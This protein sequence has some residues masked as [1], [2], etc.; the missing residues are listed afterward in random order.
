MD[1]YLTQITPEV[2]VATSEMYLTTTTVVAAPDG[3]CLVIDPAITPADVAALA[4]ELKARGLTPVA[5]FA[6]HSHWD[7]VLWSAE[8]GDVPRY[9]SLGTTRAAV[10]RRDDILASAEQSAPGH[11]AGLT[12][13][14]TPLPAGRAAV[15]WAGPL[16]QV[17]IHDGHAPG[18]TAVFLPG[19]GVLVAGDMLSDVEIPLLDP[20]AADPLGDYQAGLD[21][22]A[23]LPG[24]RH[25]VPGHGHVGDAA[26][27]G[28]RAG[29]D[30]AYLAALG[31]GDDFTDPR[32]TQNWLDDMHEQQLSRARSAAS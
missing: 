22:L 11:E 2:L 23:A 6:T 7:H 30:R 9:A 15:P 4:A 26:E 31:R 20:E 18:H 19:T 16:A 10:D 32:I 3:G 21:R 24:V 13:R 25:L 14:L 8:L 17:V 29:A 28:R 12:G 5:G 1:W 27:F